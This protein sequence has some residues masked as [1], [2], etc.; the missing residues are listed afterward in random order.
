MQQ[1]RDTLEEGLTTAKIAKVLDRSE[2]T[3]RN[4]FRSGELRAVRLQNGTHVASAA[5]VERKRQEL[6]AK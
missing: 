4:W 1:S 3:I 6:S 2:A 5:D